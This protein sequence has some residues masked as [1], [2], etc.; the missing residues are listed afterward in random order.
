MCPLLPGI[1]R[2]FDPPS[3]PLKRYIAGYSKILDEIK[4]RSEAFTDIFDVYKCDVK[5]LPYVSSYLGLDLNEAMSGRNTRKLLANAVFIYQRK[6]TI[7]GIK[8]FVSTLTGWVTEVVEN[9]G[10]S[11][12][13]YC[14]KTQY[15]TDPIKADKVALII[16]YVGDFIPL[17]TMYTIDV[18][19]P[20]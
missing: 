18:T 19:I 15:D 3:K 4:S 8:S 5:F 14:N 1:Y 7:L 20:L 6:G 10:S 11:I 17:G 12:I 2:K 9:T 13:I 16:Q